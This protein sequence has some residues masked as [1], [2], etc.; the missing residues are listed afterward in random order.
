ML[1]IRCLPSG[2]LSEP[3]TYT[4]SNRL[5]HLHFSLCILTHNNKCYV[6]EY[7]SHFVCCH[8]IQKKTIKILYYTFQTWIK[9]ALFTQT[10][11]ILHCHSTAVLRKAENRHTAPTPHSYQ[12]SGQHKRAGNKASLLF[13]RSL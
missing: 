11:D 3:A 4:L 2:R 8:S 6:Q 7:T 13:E 5:A 1:L 12:L 9:C 10:L